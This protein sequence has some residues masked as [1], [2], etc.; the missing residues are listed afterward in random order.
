MYQF[1]VET[2]FTSN[3]VFY[4]HRIIRITGGQRYFNEIL[5]HVKLY[6]VFKLHHIS[7]WKLISFH[8]L[9]KLI[10]LLIFRKQIIFTR[11]ARWAG[12]QSNWLM[13]EIMFY[14]SPFNFKKDS[15]FFIIIE[16]LKVLKSNSKDRSKVKAFCQ[17][18]NTLNKN[19][20]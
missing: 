11:N 1:W 10:L 8:K 9:K 3:T 20:I 12:I 15:Q 13:F 17:K 16:R 5:N 6:I 14:F 18:K 19:N 7:L 2:R 4:L